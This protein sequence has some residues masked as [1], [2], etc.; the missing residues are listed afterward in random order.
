[1]AGSM[2][3]PVQAIVGATIG[4]IFLVPLTLAWKSLS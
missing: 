2:H 1:M 3:P 4:L